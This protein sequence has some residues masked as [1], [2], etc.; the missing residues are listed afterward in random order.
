MIDLAHARGAVCLGGSNRHAGTAHHCDV[1]IR[2]TLYPHTSLREI[3]WQR[4]HSVT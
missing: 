1:A 4:R 3:C 2:R